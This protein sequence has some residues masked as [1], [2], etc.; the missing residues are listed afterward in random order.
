[1]KNLHLHGYYRIVGLVLAV[2]GILGSMMLAASAP[3]E[4][5]LVIIVAGTLASVISCLPLFAIDEH[6]DNQEIIQN[7]LEALAYELHEANKKENAAAS[8]EE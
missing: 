8:S 5:G 3:D 1:M 2:L 7:Q 6:L 4:L